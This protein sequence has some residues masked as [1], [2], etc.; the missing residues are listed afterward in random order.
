MS[1]TAILD[2]LT[3]R[4][5]TLYTQDGRLRYRGPSGAYTPE[6]RAQVAE[7]RA[8]LVKLLDPAALIERIAAQQAWLEK[9]SDGLSSEE[10]ERRI[11]RLS[12]NIDAVFAAL[13]AEG[14]TVEDYGW[15]FSGCGDQWR[16]TDKV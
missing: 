8:A 10:H 5:L 9:H 13:A 16:K 15:T 12:A 6:L 2:A 3:A 7:H 4:G 1:A 11:M 14:K